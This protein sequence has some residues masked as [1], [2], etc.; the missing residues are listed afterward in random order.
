[1][2]VSIILLCSLKAT[3][4]GICVPAVNVL[5]ATSQSSELIIIIFI[6][7]SWSVTCITNQAFSMFLFSKHLLF[8]YWYFT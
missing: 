7:P 6:L 8:L 1:V 4:T 5:N 3:V 2:S